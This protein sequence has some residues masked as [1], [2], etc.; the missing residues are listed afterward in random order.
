MLKYTKKSEMVG[1]IIE[2]QDLVSKYL[3]YET[4]EKETIQTY[5]DELKTVSFDNDAL[6]T[7]IINN[8]E[9]ATTQI[10]NN[11]LDIDSL[12]NVLE[13]LENQKS[14]SSDDVETY[15]KLS[16]KTLKNMELTQNFIQKT[17]EC[18]E[19]VTMNV[20]K[21]SVV[22]LDECKNTLLADFPF[23]EK[24]AKPSAKKSAD[25]NK[26]TSKYIKKDFDFSAS[27][28]LCFFPQN[29][30]DNLV[31][32]TSRNNYKIS[33]VGKTASIIIEEENFNMSLATHGVQISNTNT[34]NILF[35]S[36]NNG[37][38]TIVTNNQIEIPSYIHVCKVSK[39]DD[40]L[41][42]EISRDSVELEVE[43]N[44]LNFIDNG[45]DNINDNNSISNIAD[46]DMVAY[47]PS[48]KS[49]KYTGL[50][51]PIP[52]KKVTKIE[53]K[54]KVENVV[55]EE[56]EAPSEEVV[57]SSPSILPGV[58]E[59][60]EPAKESIPTH[61]SEPIKLEEAAKT[62]AEDVP[63]KKNSKAKHAAETKN[64]K[65]LVSDISNFDI[66]NENGELVDND[67]LIISDPYQTVVL[68]YKVEELE[69]KLEKNKK[70]K[71]IKDVLENEY[72]I[73]LDS[74]KDPIKSRFREAFQLV[75]K[76]ERGSLKEAVG[77]G[78]ELMFQSNLNPAIIAACKDLDELDI[79]L[80]CLD[81]NELEKFNCF[82]I[83]YSVPP[84]SK[85]KK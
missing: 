19:N 32:S 28:L 68:P 82:K 4:Q 72:V 46:S 11:L 34:N 71:S 84:T 8:F 67:T 27:D 1:A 6:K 50:N 25:D 45:S 85:G 38:Y 43:D 22:I 41:E 33:F 66:Y 58:A 16:T 10:D 76:K 24:P 49:I 78:F 23:V 3:D 64:K 75:K 37:H 79:Y 62:V 14:V 35:I 69:K 80:D 81:D 26:L 61:V 2:E 56:I 83:S 47:T 7:M 57:E 60:I 20:K 70:Y 51:N 59:E 18:F 48:V 63:S 52:E 65:D 13:I 74:F 31:I 77:L 73:P 53:D 29:K 42:I 17:I 54:P 21:K 9:N 55:E 44:I 40:F 36:Q 15:N 39:N 5:L 30:D 12:K